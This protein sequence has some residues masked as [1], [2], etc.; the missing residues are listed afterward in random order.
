M[1]RGFMRRLALL[2]ERAGSM[3]AL[4]REVGVVD[5]TIRKW[6]AGQ[7]EPTRRHLVTLAHTGGVSLEWL[8]LGPG[9]SDPAPEPLKA[10]TPAL[11]STFHARVY[12]ALRDAVDTA[13]QVC[14]YAPPDGVSEVVTANV[15]MAAA[16]AIHDLGAESSDEEADTQS[17][18]AAQQGEKCDD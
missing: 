3:S 1:D 2:A 7:S 12:P 17:S 14:G 5:G 15:Y 8:I 6:I 11:T 13:F 9:D 16:W 10:P 18:Q 4:A